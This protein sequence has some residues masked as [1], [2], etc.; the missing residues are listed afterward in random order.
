MKITFERFAGYYA[1]LAGIVG[2]LYSLAY[3]ILK[4]N[5]ASALFLLLGSIF[6]SAALVALYER[7]QQT[8]QSFALW[9]LLLALAGTLGS[10]I[11]TGY[12]LS[13][14]INTPAT[15]NVDIPSAIDPRGLATFGLAGLGLIVFSWLIVRGH[16]FP[17]NFGYLGYL[18]AVLMLI[19]YLGRLIILSANTLVIAIPALLEGF[20]INPAW[21]FWL[22]TILLRRK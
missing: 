4:S 9:G 3:I 10:V 12:D 21:Y 8:D 17:P 11:H 18:S 22:G 13:N 6:A 5:L 14:A 2:F 16:K 7:L 15:I 1:V 19:L 20:I